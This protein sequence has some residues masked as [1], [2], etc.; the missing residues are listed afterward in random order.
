V[1]QGMW[2]TVITVVKNDAVGFGR[3]LDSLQGQDLSG[4]EFIIIDGSDDSD[5]IPSLLQESAVQA[6]YYWEEPAGIYAAMN[7]GLRRAQGDYCYF[8]NA[9]DTLFTLDVITRS[10]MFAV[11]GPTWMFGPVEIVSSDGTKVITPH[12]DYENEKKQCFSR[13]LFPC[14]QGTFVRTE[15]LRGLGGFSPHFT[16]V[17]DYAMFLELSR[18]SNPQELDF[19]V[20]SFAEGGISTMRWRESLREFHKARMMILRPHGVQL[21]QERWNTAAGFARMLAYR[22]LMSKLRRR[23]S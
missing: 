10:R 16:I 12:W 22:G 8:A 5:E 14:H 13:G 17:S 2:L 7:E 6:H 15:V 1:S 9:G 4:V 19:V 3:T 18:I 21:A 11:E 23:P 20:A